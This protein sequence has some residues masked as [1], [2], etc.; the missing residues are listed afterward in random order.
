M[1]PDL[2]KRVAQL[3]EEVLRRSPET[4]AQFL[5]QACADAPELRAELDKM[6][7]RHQDADRTN[8]R[9][10]VSQ[11]TLGLE[12][13]PSPAV[14][15][16]PSQ[17]PHISPARPGTR[18]TDFIQDLFRRRLRIVTLCCAVLLG[19]FLVKDLLLGSYQVDELFFVHL[20][21][22]L[23][24]LVLSAIVWARPA[25]SITSL[26][27]V[28]VLCV[29]VGGFYLVQFEVDLLHEAPAWTARA[30]D[31]EV[32]ASITDRISLR[33]F[34]GLLLYGLYV[35]NTLRR[36]LA[37]LGTLAAV[38]VVVAV[39]VCAR[40]GFLPQATEA[41][42]EMTI[43]MTLGAVLAVY[44]SHKIAILRRSGFEARKLGQYRILRLL[45]AGGMGEV[46]LAEHVLLKRRAALKVIRPERIDDAGMVRRFER[47]VQ[48][49][50]GLNHAHIMSIYDYG[51]AEDGTFYY[52][53]EY[54]RGLDLYQLVKRYGPLP[55]GRAIHFLRQAG[56]ALQ[57]AHAVGLIHRDV[58]PNNILATAQPGQWDD[59]KLFDFGLV[60]DTRRQAAGESMTHAN[61]L[62]GTPS[63]MSPEQV[64]GTRDV[65]ARSDL[66]SLGA[67]G[68]FL[69]TGA[70]PF[71]GELY[72]HV[73][74]A[75]LEEPVTPPSQR[76]AGV[77]ADLEAVILKCL[78]KDPGKRFGSAADLLESLSRCGDA[79]AW[80][81]ADAAAWWQER[82]PEEPTTNVS[83]GSP[84]V[85]A[86]LP[87]AAPAM[88]DV[89]DNPTVPPA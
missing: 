4:R 68:Y 69:L 28:E 2:H 57:A 60:R 15:V 40:A 49:M 42:V 9:S 37:V 66:Y 23:A 73:L 53:M 79:A 38:P 10:R 47:E 78:E 61:A 25:L 39:L 22:T 21:A 6:L 64:A 35:P 18:Y 89:H 45:A 75:H 63:Y 72:L 5:D 33:W 41:L 32:L 27:V 52:V 71:V 48:A 43:W 3:F 1:T 11:K 20:G 84:T 86:A 70:P 31:P 16:G 80:T 8:W 85:D 7:A 34:M 67:V 74:M 51:H 46:Y 83:L 77:S 44:A 82:Q 13:V 12:D 58:K 54:V 29:G 19:L 17:R 56:A 30:G 36:T 14:P 24:T 55:A 88:G 76:V 50:A 65:D 87:P 81:R 62:L 59:V 26:R